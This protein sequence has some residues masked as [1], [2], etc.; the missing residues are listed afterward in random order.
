MEQEMEQVFEMKVKERNQRLIDSEDDL[1]CREGQMKKSLEK[2]RREIEDKK[3][4]MESEK[5][6]WEQA[7]GMTFDELRRRSL[8]ALSKE[9]V[10]GKKAKKKGIF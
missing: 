6:A 1:R 10:D 8:E 5:Y 3:K 7:N 2:L 9:T 4:H